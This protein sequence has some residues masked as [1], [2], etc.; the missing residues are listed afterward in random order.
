MNVTIGGYSALE[1]ASY[2]TL[3]HELTYT[4]TFNEGSKLVYEFFSE[5]TMSCYMFADGKGGFKTDRKWIDKI[6]ENSDKLVKGENIDS[7]F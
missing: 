4:V 2:D 5:S 1:G 7:A 3:K 6:I